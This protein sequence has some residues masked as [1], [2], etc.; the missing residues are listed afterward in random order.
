MYSNE[1]ETFH[2]TNFYVFLLFQNAGKGPESCETMCCDRGFVTRREKRVERCKCKF[3]WCCFVQCE[4]CY[5]E[6][7]VST[8][9]WMY[10]VCISPISRKNPV[11]NNTGPVLT[12]MRGFLLDP[13]KKVSKLLSK[14]EIINVILKDPKENCNIM[15]I[16]TT[17]KYFQKRNLNFLPPTHSHTIE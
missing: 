15:K 3:H 9:N 13:T 6:V 5:R 10:L 1:D 4:E 7:E 11:F 16:E 8:C 14:N 12:Y 2:M 17:F